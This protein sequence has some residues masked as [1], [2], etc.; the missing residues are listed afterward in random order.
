MYERENQ[1]WYDEQIFIETKVPIDHSVK[2]ILQERWGNHFL[3]REEIQERN[4]VIAGF[5]LVSF[6]LCFYFFCC[7]PLFS[8][9]IRG[10]WGDI[11]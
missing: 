10:S 7:N 6:L 2:G 8:P 9:R 3:E 4:R 1:E 11:K 5:L